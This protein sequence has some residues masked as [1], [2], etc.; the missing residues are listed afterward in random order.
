MCVICPTR[1]ISEKDNKAPMFDDPMYYEWGPNQQIE[2]TAYTVAVTEFRLFIEPLL[3]LSCL[4]FKIGA[5]HLHVSAQ[6]I[7]WNYIAIW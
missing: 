5:A 2:Q 6:D 1:C 7:K 3:L 4:R